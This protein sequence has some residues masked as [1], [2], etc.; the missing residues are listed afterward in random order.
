MAIVWKDATSYSRGGDRTPK[1][2]EVRTR[3]LRIIVTRC[4]GLEG[5]WLL[6]HDLGIEMHRTLST[7]DLELAK[8]NALNTVRDK[9][10]TMLREIDSARV[11]PTDA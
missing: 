3:S 4:H 2:W 6:C 1:T 10:S 5:W 7:D 8:A 11:N 9:L